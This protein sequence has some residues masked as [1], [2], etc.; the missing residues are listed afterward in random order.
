MGNECEVR[1]G[2]SPQLPPIQPALHSCCVYAYDE[3]WPWRSVSFSSSVKWAKAIED[4]TVGWIIINRTLGTVP[5]MRYWERAGGHYC[6]YC[7]SYSFTLCKFQY[8]R[9]LILICMLQVVN[10][11]VQRLFHVV[12][13]SNHSRCSVSTVAMNPV[14]FS[15]FSP[16][17]VQLKL[18]KASFPYSIVHYGNIRISWKIILTVNVMK[19]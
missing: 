8:L 17:V 12:G 16:S 1:I 2:D 6:Y 11:F 3:V 10:C 7:C 14:K 19:I 13:L 18:L 9:L 5:D 15:F 4:C